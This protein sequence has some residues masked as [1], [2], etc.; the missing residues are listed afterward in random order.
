M[1]LYQIVDDSGRLMQP[2]D[3][4]ALRSMAVAGLLKPDTK[5]VDTKTGDSIR[6]SEVPG[7][8]RI[9]AAREPKR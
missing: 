4:N 3:E 5:L 1:R 6:A 9:A 8:T 2:L 7:V